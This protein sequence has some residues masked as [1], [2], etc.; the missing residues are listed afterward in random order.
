MQLAL[1][2]Q[3]EELKAAA[4]Y[5]PLSKLKA[6]PAAPQSPEKKSPVNPTALPANASKAASSPAPAASPAA[7]AAGAASKAVVTT[8]LA[9]KRGGGSGGVR[10]QVGRGEAS[11]KRKGAAEGVGDVVA[12]PKSA[13][14]QKA[15]AAASASPKANSKLGPKPEP[16]LGGLKAAKGGKAPGSKPAPQSGKTQ[17]GDVKI[18]HDPEGMVCFTLAPL[19]DLPPLSNGSYSSKTMDE[20]TTVM[21]I[22][23]MVMDH[24]NKVGRS[25]HI[26]MVTF[27]I[28]SGMQLGNDHSLK[29]IRR[30]L[31]PPDKGRLDIMYSRDVGGGFL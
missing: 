2:L 19:D 3:N 16:H 1:Q 13:K 31:W 29:Y 27:R 23:R 21:Q 28:S 9:P 14:K 11:S 22:K 10:M 12:S 15:S 7:S 25:G 26:E 5:R 8:R 18:K 30:F 24:V 6:S 17:S 4:R 20:E